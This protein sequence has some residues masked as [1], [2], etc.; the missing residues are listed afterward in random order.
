MI[1]MLM[2]S[3]SAQPLVIAH[4]G[5]SGYLPEH[6]LEAY[7]L[8]YGQG[9]DL[10]EPDVVLSRDNVLVCSHD[11]TLER[12]TNVEEVFPLRKRADG[13]WYVIDFDWSEIESLTVDG[14]W[15][16]GT[17]AGH[18]GLRKVRLSEMAALLERLNETTGRSVGII[19]E[20]KNAAFHQAE[21]KDLVAAL[22]AA[23]RS[24]KDLRVVI[25]S[26]EAEALKKFQSLGT[27][28]ERVFLF[29]TLP[30]LESAGGLAGVKGFASGI[31]PNW[32]LLETGPLLTDAR[33][34]GLRVYP[35]TFD[36]D[37]SVMKRYFGEKAVDG[38]FTDFPDKGVAARSSGGK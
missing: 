29:S 17:S 11:L 26:F 38:L 23:V 36:A 25:Q 20:P 35:W 19:P 32:R 27:P 30:A 34:A 18:K 1:A 10:I 12:T 31:G 13:K 3:V 28:G 14:P 7:S 4:R 37:V 6:T 5:A 16:R 8:A 21:G 33:K 9:A 22:D 2:M 15:V 24:M